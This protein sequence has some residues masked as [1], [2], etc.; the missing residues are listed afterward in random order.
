MNS[1]QTFA[2]KG[3][4]IHSMDSTRLTATPDS[5]LVCEEGRVAGVYS[6]LPGQFAG[7]TVVDWG[8]K[9]IIP[10]LCDLH[11]H[12][13][14]YAFRGLGMDLELLDWLNDRTFPEEAKYE[15]Y[16]Y[17]DK[18][19]SIFAD[20][21]RNSAT[22]RA[23]I[24]ATIHVPA[25]EILMEKLEGTGIKAMVGKVLTD[26]NSPE[27]LCEDS[28]EQSLSDTRLW[29]EDCVEHFHNVTPILTP[30]F[31]P[32]CSDALLAGLGEI[33]RET[34]LPVQSHLSES[35][36]ESAWVGQ[37]CPDA[38]FYGETYDRHGL[39]GGGGFAV[40]AHCVHS[41]EAEIELMRERGVFVAHC[42]QS[43]MN[44]SSGVA[45]VRGLM[46]HG[47]RVGLGSD[48]AGG[49]SLSIFRAMSDAVQASKLRWCLLGDTSRPLSL[50]EAFYLGTRGGGAFFGKVGAFDPGF[51][52][53]AVVLDD[54]TLPHPLPLSPLER[55][56][57]AICLS[58]ER[59]IAAKYIAGIQVL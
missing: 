55:L 19:Y 8:D 34:G 22:T 52:C 3:H 26:R 2:L 1:Q 17:A 23:C 16:E 33:Q 57:R 35:L 59:H 14:Q 37:L 44:L 31:T 36:Q 30:R 18:A 12:A 46:E 20:A 47:V 58:D 13:P 43:N 11:L 24:F 56:E 38:L 10:G 45:P 9:L 32:S 5:Y 50:P 7:I 6:S 21:L 15:D 41:G 29:L 4:I 51:E 27:N 54:S 39:F 49:F 28:A 40:M 53:D 42:P 25:T 48:M